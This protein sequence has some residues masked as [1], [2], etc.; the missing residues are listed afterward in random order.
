MPVSP[1]LVE[2]LL[3]GRL[4][5]GPAAI[6]D[7]LSTASL[8]S[9]TIAR[10]YDV[11]EALETEPATPDELA[12]RFDLDARGV[13]ALLAFLAETG[14]VTESGGRYENTTLTRRWLLESTEGGMGAYFVFWDQQVL[15]FWNEQMGHALETGTPEQNFYAWLS[16][17]PNGWEHAQAAFKETAEQTAAEVVAEVDCSAG[18]TRLL[19][20]GGGHGLYSARFCQAYPD[21]EATVFDDPD[22]LATARETISETG[23][24]GR[25]SV[26]GGDFTTDDLGDGY[27]VV[28]L[29]NV[30][31]GGDDLSS[32]FERVHDA[33]DP[34]GRVVIM[35]QFDETGRMNVQPAMLRLLDLT[36]LGMLGGGLPDEETTREQLRAAGF[37]TI[38][39]I[40]LESVRGIT[41]LVATAS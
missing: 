1:N 29:F 8:R 21:L 22:A 16:E 41:L 30:L 12:E 5:K 9:V 38:E 17:Q 34:G 33:L 37:E 14:Y 24:A 27:D 2:R 26:Q 25:L 35:D 20:V 28:L 11:F 7:L 3:L 32:L 15:P 18:E 31:H 6:L 36:Y 19:D 23:L 10:E 40:D 13:G 4:Q 39:R